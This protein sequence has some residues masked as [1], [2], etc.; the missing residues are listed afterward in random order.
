DR[1]ENTTRFVLVGRDPVVPTG[2]D[3]TSVVC[4]IE[5]DRPGALLAI[6][7][8]FSDRGINLTKLESRPTK[9]RLGEYCFFIDVEG[10]TEDPDVRHAI[11]GL[12]TKILDVH[13]LGS[14]PRA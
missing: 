12:R 3:K 1:R 10:H 9:E 6:L 5:K 7:H 14:Y 8:E 13:V 4:F 11:A 2:K